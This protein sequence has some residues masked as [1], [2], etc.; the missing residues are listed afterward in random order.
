MNIKVHEYTGMTATA[1]EIRSHGCPV[2]LCGPFTEQ[3]HDAARWQAWVAELGG[4]RVRLVWVRSDAE[5]LRR[6]L[7]ARGSDR[8]TE[9]L[10]DFASFTTRMRLDVPPAAPHHMIDN[11]LSAAAT[12]PDQVAALLGARHHLGKA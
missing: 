6:R 7:T 10:A 8:D 11:R 3:I 4:S 5:T 2:I 1:R 9:K 12:V